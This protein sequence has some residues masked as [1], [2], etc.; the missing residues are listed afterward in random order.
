[1][2]NELLEQYLFLTDAECKEF[3]RKLWMINP[4]SHEHV[5][6]HTNNSTETE[7]GDIYYGNGVYYVSHHKYGIESTGHFILSWFLPGKLERYNV[8][9]TAIKSPAGREKILNLKYTYC[10]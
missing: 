7:S 9:E 5:I 8:L 3:N 4:N 1:M 2:S 6:P 10:E